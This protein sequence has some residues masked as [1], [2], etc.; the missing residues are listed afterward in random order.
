[1]RGNIV[2]KHGARAVWLYTR[3]L[4]DL[5]PEILQN[6]LLRGKG[7]WGDTATL[8]NIIHSEM[9]KFGCGDDKAFGISPFMTD[10]GGM[11]WAID[12]VNE[13]VGCFYESGKL[14][15]TWAFA[16]FLKLEDLNITAITGNASF[17]DYNQ[18][19]V[20]IPNFSQVGTMVHVSE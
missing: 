1:M 14:L 20:A 2:V 4:G 13:Q 16:A 8:T 17:E 12:D 7:S 6:A 11:V 10:N 3:K 15:R 19:I 9:V 18:Q 5:L